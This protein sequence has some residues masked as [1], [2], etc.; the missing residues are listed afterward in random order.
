MRKYVI[1]RDKALIYTDN[2]MIQ[3]WEEAKSLEQLK[4]FCDHNVDARYKE[5]IRWKG[6]KVPAD[7]FKQVLGTI[8][9]YPNMETAYSLLYRFSDQSWKIV[10]T[11]Q[12]GTGASVRSEVA[13]VEDGYQEIGNIHTHPN[14]SA[15]WSGTDRADMEKR[16]GVFL[17]LGLRHGKPVENKCCIWT[18]YGGHDIDIW[19]VFEKVDLTKDY[20]P[21]KDWVKVIDQQNRPTEAPQDKLSIFE[22]VFGPLKRIKGK[23]SSSKVIQMPTDDDWGV[24]RYIPQETQ[25]IRAIHNTLA[26]LPDD[27]VKKVLN[28]YLESI[29]SDMLVMTPGDI[30]DAIA[31]EFEAAE[32]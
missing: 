29:G 32:P 17:V 21:N 5:G 14:M 23:T 1:G 24:P 22:N 10:A 3:G 28:A 27:R 12:T 7:M 6:G 2:E 9:K 13:A 26:G 20:K 15:F 25:W 8:Q 30:D 16:F 11:D 31:E 19:D 4:L 18:P